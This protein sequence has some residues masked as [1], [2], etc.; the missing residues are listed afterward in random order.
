MTDPIP[1]IAT[2]Y[3]YIQGQAA[4]STSSLGGITQRNA[5]VLSEYTD[6]CRA[7][8]MTPST[9]RLRLHWLARAGREVDLQTA[10]TRDLIGFLGAHDWQPETRKSARNA[11][12]SFYRWLVEDERRPDD[13]SSRLP[14]VRVPAGVPRPAP[15][16]VL[17]RAL[18]V[19]TDRDQLI[20]G[21]AAFAGLRRS[22][23][24][25]LEWR[26]VEWSGL[27]VHG[28]G[29]RTRTVPILPRLA[30]MLADERERR[31]L[32]GVGT[33]WRYTVDHLSPYVLPSH[34]GGHL[35]PDRIGDVLST[36]LGDQWTG[37]T[38]RHRFATLAYSV[39]RDLLTVQQLLGH[40]KPETTARYTAIPHGAALAAV[41]GAAA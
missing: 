2:N 19:A 22:E 40:S 21:L 16:D 12:R 33:G 26:A 5:L 1:R 23:I 27:R 15:T 37:H 31:E 6:W 20:L 39:D 3:L 17:T 9:I 28:K 32:G 10:T 35:S 13:P 18:A 30:T 14:A 36:A 25:A 38:L 8:G 11:L 4:S 7:S 29:G 34:V 24:A 41:Q